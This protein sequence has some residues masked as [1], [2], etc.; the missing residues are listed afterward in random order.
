[1][2]ESFESLALSPAL[3]DDATKLKELFAE[4]RGTTTRK[5]AM[6][7]RDEASERCYEP[8]LVKIIGGEGGY[9]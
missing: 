6:G 5:A 4:D 1:M 3:G 9:S 2:G 8:I 7:L